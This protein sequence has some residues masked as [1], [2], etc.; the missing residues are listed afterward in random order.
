MSFTDQHVSWLKERRALLRFIF[1]VKRIPLEPGTPDLLIDE[2]DVGALIDLI[3]SGRKFNLRDVQRATNPFMGAAGPSSS[4]SPP[5]A[6][7]NPFEHDSASRDGIPEYPVTRGENGALDVTYADHPSSS[8]GSGL[9]APPQL[10]LPGLADAGG[11]HDSHLRSLVYLVFLTCTSHSPDKALLK[12]MRKQLRIGDARARELH[13]ALS[14]AVSNGVAARECVTQTLRLPL[15]MLQHLR[16]EAFESFA[17]FSAWRDTMCSM[18]SVMLARAAGQWHQHQPQQQYDGSRGV[19]GGANGIGPANGSLGSAQRQRIARLRACMRRLD[20]TCEEDYDVDEYE[21]ALEALAVVADGIAAE[22]GCGY[23][24]PFGMR[25]CLCEMMLSGVFESSPPPGAPGAPPAG[26]G[27]PVGAETF[28]DEKEDLLEMLQRH[29]WPALGISRATHNALYAWIHF[30]QFALTGNMLLL[31]PAKRLL[32]HLLEEQQEAG[33]MRAAALPSQSLVSPKQGLYPTLG[34]TTGSKADG[35]GGQ[36]DEELPTA[37][38]EAVV[39][40][41]AAR[42][43]DYHASF[44]VN[45]KLMQNLLEILMLAESYR[46]GEDT[47]HGL[48]AQCV[49]TSLAAEFART[50]RDAEAAKPERVEQLGMLA[51]ATR[52]L[53]ATEVDRYG[54]V[55]SPCLPDH[56]SQVAA[57]LHKAYGA[58]ILPW[59]ESGKGLDVSVVKLVRTAEELEEDLQKSMKTGRLDVWGLSAAI[60]PLLYDWVSDKLAQLKT[61]TDRLIEKEDWRGVTTTQPC[62]RSAIEM[63]KLCM[64]SV[65]S[66][67]EMRLQLPTELV[68]TL[69]EGLDTSI[70]RYSDFVSSSVGSVDSLA[71]PAPPLTRYKRELWVKSVE[72]EA[73]GKRPPL[74][75]EYTMKALAVPGNA[76]APLGV[77]RNVNVTTDAL[78]VRMNCLSYL[79]DAL[80]QVKASVQERW[81][82]EQNTST[83]TRQK[84]IELFVG[85]LAQSSKNLSASMDRMC[86][87]TAYKVVW[88]DMSKEWNEFLYRWSVNRGRMDV[89]LQRLDAVLSQLCRSCAESLSEPLARNMLKASA[90]AYKRV[91][92]DGGSTRWYTIEDIPLLQEDLAAL[93]QFFFAGGDGLSQQE[94]DKR[95]AQLSQLVQ[96]MRMDTDS[97]VGH[98][99]KARTAFPGSDG[100][101]LLSNKDVLLRVLCH[102]AERNASKF[103]KSDFRIPKKT[104]NATTTFLS[105]KKK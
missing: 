94:I 37:V 89:V 6:N 32:Q 47:V 10:T 66:L 20:V 90:A 72:A 22:S 23:A 96:V 80:P 42:M 75:D 67:F 48:V 19:D 15:E 38:S 5:Q 27:S 34:S 14:V 85:V 13:K 74:L 17:V 12:L 99:Q 64:Q 68:R 46:L 101:D 51:H 35:I 36:G 61:W 9:G 95:T 87:Y 91:L 49:D 16:P 62:G 25:I 93:K 45:T 8:N 29:V 55:L 33:L 2:A 24:L 11:V 31:R 39:G 60:V 78:I 97:L 81:I 4:N 28:V 53:L 77:Q 100:T 103:L 84:S 88:W 76:N 26:G 43:A 50:R 58:L 70:S 57:A 104:G 79:F 21:D 7:S 59:F 92:L 40:W 52:E 63:A 82:A 69:L 41:I 18:L 73:K 3:R 105:F 71:P 1:E 86:K 30:R 56:Q 98:F 44:G 102:R 65:D 83:V 54:P